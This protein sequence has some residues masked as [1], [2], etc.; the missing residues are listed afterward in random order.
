MSMKNSL[1]TAKR[2]HEHSLKSRPVCAARLPPSAAE[3]RELNEAK[4]R[5]RQRAEQ[6]MKVNSGAKIKKQRKGFKVAKKR[7]VQVKGGTA[8]KKGSK[9]VN[10]GME[11]D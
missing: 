6:T 2:Q 1:A 4:A 10:Q 7:K 3:E 9:A 11:L 5:K 8:D